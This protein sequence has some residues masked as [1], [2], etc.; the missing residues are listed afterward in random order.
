MKSRRSLFSII[1]NRLFLAIDYQRYPVRDEASLRA[2]V[3]V[4]FAG[5]GL[6]VKVEHHNAHGRS[7]LGGECRQ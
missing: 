1:L 6:D 7:D 2:Y 4:Y 5:A 3:Q